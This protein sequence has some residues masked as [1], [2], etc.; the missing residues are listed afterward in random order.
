MHASFLVEQRLDNTDAFMMASCDG[1]CVYRV[2]L[3]LH[4]N[5]TPHRCHSRLCQ[6]SRHP[7]KS[8]MQYRV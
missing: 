8:S 7:S 2:Q 5:H 3:R 1:L 4:E 6:R